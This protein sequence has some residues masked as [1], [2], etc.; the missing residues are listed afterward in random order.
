MNKITGNEYCVTEENVY[1]IHELDYNDGDICFIGN[2]TKLPTI[3]NVDTVK[4]EMILFIFCS[5]GKLDLRI[6]SKSIT[7]NPGEIL[8]CGPSTVLEDIM[9]SP[10][11]DAKILGISTKIIHSLV[12]SD[13]NILSQYF[14]MRENPIVSLGKDSTQLVSY[15]YDIV[16]YRITLPKRRYD[17]E[18]IT[19]LVSAALYDLLNELG[20]PT[21]KLGGNK[22]LITQGDMLFGRFLELLTSSH[23]KP[24]SVSWYG[25]QLCVTPKYL[26]TTV[27]EASGKTALKWIT[28]YVIEDI[29]RLLLHS[30]LTIKEI[31]E[32]LKF[33]NLSF[34]GK[35]CKQHLGCSPTEYRKTKL[36]TEAEQQ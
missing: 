17:K 9:V 26:S 36:Q 11:Y 28:D 27:K 3:R 7:M 23:P 24:R 13:K 30:N 33:P 19:A 25:Q 6:R 35:Y 10:D 12:R 31:A 32:A 34:F 1:N 20:E 4:V 5:A 21:V 29:R 22:E 8:C 15:Y 2:L 18:A 16:K 14:N